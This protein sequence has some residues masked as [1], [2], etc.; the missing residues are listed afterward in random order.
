MLV[1]NP[2]CH[3]LFPTNQPTFGKKEPAY[4][5]KL[6]RVSLVSI[7]SNNALSNKNSRS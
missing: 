2:A 1:V 3:R 7:F 5:L 4:I 6:A